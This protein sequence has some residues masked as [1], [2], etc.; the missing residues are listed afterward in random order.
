MNDCINC[1][2]LSNEKKILI[3]SIYLDFKKSVNKDCERCLEQG[4]K[5]PQE[6]ADEINNGNKGIRT[7]DY[8][9]AALKEEHFKNCSIIGVEDIPI[10]EIGPMNGMLMGVD[11]RETTVGDFFWLYNRVKGKQQNFNENM[12]VEFPI[13]LVTPPCRAIKRKLD[14]VKL[15]YYVEDGN[16]RLLKWIDL[17][18]KTVPAF[19]I[20]DPEYAPRDTDIMP[21]FMQNIK[22]L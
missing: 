14:D 15:K 19:V 16:H 2:Q 17:G 6:L 7:K 18:N 11:L 12:M 9:R 20:I 10:N 22:L 1:N 3:N 5:D 4:S 13:I 8:I 21:N